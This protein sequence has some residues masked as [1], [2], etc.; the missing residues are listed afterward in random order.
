MLLLLHGIYYHDA[1]QIEFF[2]AAFLQWFW[3]VLYGGSLWGG[4]P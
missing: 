4:Q 1:F 2:N 3:K